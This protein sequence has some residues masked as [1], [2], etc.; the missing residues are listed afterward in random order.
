MVQAVRGWLIDAE[1]WVQSHISLSGM[2]AAKSG[3]QVVFSE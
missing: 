2:F 1:A 3:M